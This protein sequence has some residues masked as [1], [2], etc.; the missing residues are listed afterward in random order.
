MERNVPAASEPGIQLR[1]FTMPRAIPTQSPPSTTPNPTGSGAN[2]RIPLS[3]SRIWLQDR[4][5]STPSDLWE[6][7][8]RRRCRGGRVFTDKLSGSSKTARLEMALLDFGSAD[9]SPRSPEPSPSSA[10]DEP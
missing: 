2:T 7:T 4:S 5:I 1:I 3:P 8:R 6:L 10:N 9:P